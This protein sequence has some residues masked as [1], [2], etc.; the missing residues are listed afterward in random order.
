METYSIFGMK[1]AFHTLSHQIDAHAQHTPDRIAIVGTDRSISW[2]DLSD[3]QSAWRQRWLETAKDDDV[4]AFYAGNSAGAVAG[5]CGI[6]AAGKCIAPL[7]RHLTDET[8]TRLLSDC[9]AK[10]VVVDDDGAARLS[11]LNLPQVLHHIDGPDT[12]H[13]KAG[14]ADIAP[15]TP[16]NLTYSSGTTGKPKGI[17]QSH[18]LRAN[19][20]ASG[21][22]MGLGPAKVSILSTPLDS[23][24]TIIGLVGALWNG[25]QLVLMPKF[26]ALD[27]IEV[28]DKQKVTHTLMVPVQYERVLDHAEYATE[29]LASLELSLCTGAPLSPR[30]K[31]ELCDRWPGAILEVYGLTEGGA[32]TLLSLKD[33]PEKLHTVGQP[34]PG[35]TIL[36][37]S[38]DGTVCPTGET[39]EIV[40]RD[41]W[42]MTGYTDENLN[43]SVFWTDDEGLRYIRTGDLGAL[44]ADGFLTIQGRKKDM[45]ISGGFN[46]YPCDVESVL[47]DHPDVVE[48]AVFG[49]PSEK[50][51]ETPVAA[52]VTRREATINAEDFKAWANDRLGKTQRLSDVL[53]LD[54]LPR[55]AADKIDKNALRALP[56]S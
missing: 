46:V 11:A 49:T 40:G 18:A 4:V 32:T 15:N 39:G 38:D 10:H 28:I 37:I 34:F 8:L 25:A 50:W 52:L 45:I 48:C 17:V 30:R 51:G 36:T 7:P 41:E 31:R 19:Q 22:L 47:S 27:F 55:T 33:N 9:G 42:M 21:T 53:L 14:D 16:F 3:S 13:P 43:G 12:T 2:K 29:R 54:A 26:E 20:G 6:V 44:D 1:M 35:S 5:F 56:L 23:D 24:T